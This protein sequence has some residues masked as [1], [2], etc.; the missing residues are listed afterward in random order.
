M[1]PQQG[2]SIGPPLASSTPAVETR[3]RREDFAYLFRC[4]LD[5]KPNEIIIKDK[6]KLKKLAK[7]CDLK[8]K[9]FA[10][11]QGYNAY[12]CQLEEVTEIAKSVGAVFVLNQANVPQMVGTCFRIGT[13]YVITNNHVCNMIT[14]K[15]NVFINFN[16]K[17]GESLLDRR[18]VDCLM[19]KSEELDYA[20]LRMEE[21]SNELPPCIFSHGISIMDPNQFQWSSL[22]GQCLTLIGHPHG[23]PKQTDLLCPVVTKP[24][25][26]LEVY[27]HALRWARSDDVAEKE[28]RDSKDPRRGD[29]S[30]HNVFSMAHLGLQGSYSKTKR[31]GWLFSTPKGFFSKVETRALS[32]KACS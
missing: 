3:K 27:G 5:I 12:I 22:E 7:E 11:E 18:N 19:V 32:S 6:T 28:C 8:C 1:R 20:I 15:D 16:F 24:L 10:A 4:A 25:D 29:V 2:P 13:R 31:S 17:K 26:S 30:S 21:P 14:T 23:Q 9:N